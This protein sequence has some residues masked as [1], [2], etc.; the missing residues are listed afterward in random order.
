MLAFLSSSILTAGMDWLVFVIIELLLQ[1]SEMVTGPV[2]SP[3]LRCEDV[4]CQSKELL[5]G[6]L[7]LKQ[8][9]ETMDRDDP[10]PFPPSRQSSMAVASHCWQ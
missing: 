1:L 5:G 10:L 3:G 8:K 7:R 2:R 4:E 9:G 6:R